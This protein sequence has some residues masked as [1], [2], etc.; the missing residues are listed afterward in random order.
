VATRPVEAAR[1]FISCGQ[2]KDT[3]EAR[4]ASATKIKTKSLA[5]DPYAAID[6]QTLQGLKESIFA[7]LENSEYFIFVDFKR[8]RA[9]YF[10][11]RNLP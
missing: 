10:R 4:I 7:Q 8:E 2:N 11:I 6:V 1:I 5:F 3:D 9:H